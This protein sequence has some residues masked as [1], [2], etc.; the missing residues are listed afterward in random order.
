MSLPHFRI[1]K[2]VDAATAVTIL[3]ENDAEKHG[4][5]LS[6]RNKRIGSGGVAMLCD[7]LAANTTVQ[8]LD[9]ANNDIEDSDISTLQLA[10]S[11]NRTVT[12]IDLGRNRITTVSLNSFSRNST[13][14]RLILQGEFFF[15]L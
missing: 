14:K 4:V 15:V 2:I 1:Q 8:E 7:S 9:I 5:V 11:K 10:L 3:N 12:S 13:V 6:L